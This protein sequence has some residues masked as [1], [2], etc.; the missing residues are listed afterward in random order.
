MTAWEI[1]KYI[2]HG[3]DGYISI[4]NNLHYAICKIVSLD[5]TQIIDKQLPFPK[6]WNEIQLISYKETG[7]SVPKYKVAETECKKDLNI[8]VSLLRI[9]I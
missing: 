1:H 2:I 6:Q 7:I 9:V 3:R 8:E 5:W 4:S